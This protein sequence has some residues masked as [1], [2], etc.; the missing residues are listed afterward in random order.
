MKLHLN[1]NQSSENT[2]NK[3]LSPSKQFDVTLKDETN[4]LY[5]SVLITGKLYD[6][7]EYNYGYIPSFNRY[8]FINDISSYSDKLVIIT[9]KVDVLMSYREQLK[10]CLVYVNRQENRFNSFYYDTQYPELAYSNTIIKKFPKKFL[11]EPAYILALRG[12][13]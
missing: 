10:K 5:P 6:F 11:E 7:H 13:S 1:I 9:F 3:V 4:L 12:A 8:Y 2:L